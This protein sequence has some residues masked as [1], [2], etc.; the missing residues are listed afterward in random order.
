MMETSLCKLLFFSFAR[1]KL[2]KIL[3]YKTSVLKVFYRKSKK[4]YLD[5]AL[6]KTLSW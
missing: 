1:P 5:R 4:H 2:A 6:A 3:A